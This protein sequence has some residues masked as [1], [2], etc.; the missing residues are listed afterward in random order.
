MEVG[1]VYGSWKECLNAKQSV[2]ASQLLPVCRRASSQRLERFHLGCLLATSFQRGCCC[3]LQAL[4]GHLAPMRH[5][6]LAAWFLHV[7][8][9]LSQQTCSCCQGSPAART[10]APLCKGVA[11]AGVATVS[12]VLL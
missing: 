4:F 9:V 7:A 5:T 3:W 1:E 2:C 12:V 8:L 10:P 11:D 6:V